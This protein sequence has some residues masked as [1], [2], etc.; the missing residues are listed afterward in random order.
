MAEDLDDQPRAANFDHDTAYA[1][2][3]PTAD[4]DHLARPDPPHHCRMASF[5]TAKLKQRA[6]HG[7][8]VC[9]II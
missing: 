5:V 7:Q 2:P 9:K 4:H 1:F 6:D 8:R 3:A